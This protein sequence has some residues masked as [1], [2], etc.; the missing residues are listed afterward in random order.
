[1]GECDLGREMG[2]AGGGGEGLGD[3]ASGCCSSIRCRLIY[4]VLR[5]MFHSLDFTLC[6]QMER[7]VFCCACFI[8]FYFY[9]T[10]SSSMHL[11]I[12]WCRIVFLSPL[13]QFTPFP[14]S[15]VMGNRFQK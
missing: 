12:V 6:T 13:Y 2:G 1:M 5:F 14:S 8:F 15:G 9:L 4:F 7:A 11:M 10:A 3:D